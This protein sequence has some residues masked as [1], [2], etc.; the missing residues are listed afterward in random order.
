MEQ[1][2]IMEY[3]PTE[4]ICRV[5]GHLPYGGLTAFLQTCTL[6]RSLESDP[7][8]T[9]H[10]PPMVSMKLR[11]RALHIRSIQT[12]EEE[13]RIKC[14][15]NQ[16]S[17]L[18]SISSPSRP[19]TV[20]KGSLVH[21]GLLSR[22]FH[23]SKGSVRIYVEVHGTTHIYDK[24][25]IHWLELLHA[26]E[27]GDTIIERDGSMELVH[28]LGIPDP[29]MKL[30]DHAEIA[31]TYGTASAIAEVTCAML[32]R[33]MKECNP[34]LEWGY[35]NSNEKTISIYIPVELVIVHT[36]PIAAELEELITVISDEINSLK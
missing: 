20:V 35:A 24:S 1:V 17:E 32:Q 6:T 34:M 25:V 29:F 2:K 21:K 36:D 11:R 7:G 31:A 22:G 26:I 14:A 12:A 23:C 8:L 16:Y 19:I 9:A 13:N 33:S 27:C 3:L 10:L 4:M 30:G 18:E 5:A 15:L 28:D